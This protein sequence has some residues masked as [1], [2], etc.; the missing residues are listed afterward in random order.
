[1]HCGL[2]SSDSISKKS[3][4]AEEDCRPRATPLSDN[5][6]SGKLFLAETPQGFHICILIYNLT[7]MTTSITILKHV[8]RENMNIKSKCT[9]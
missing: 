7:N 4:M 3:T 2:A 5:P 1:M 9:L 6:F 8:Y